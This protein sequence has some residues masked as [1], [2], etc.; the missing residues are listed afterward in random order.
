MALKALAD[1]SLNSVSYLQLW[2]KMNVIFL[3]LRN[4]TLHDVREQGERSVHKH[5]LHN[6]AQ[7]PRQVHRVVQERDH[8]PRP[9][10]AALPCWCLFRVQGKL[11]IFFGMFWFS[12]FHD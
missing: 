12:D 8:A 6:A 3:Q 2:R 4:P 1:Y 9:L 10:A 11:V 7:H 5:Q